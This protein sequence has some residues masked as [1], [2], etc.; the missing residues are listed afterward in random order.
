MPKIPTRQTALF[1]DKDIQK[2]CRPAL[3]MKFNAADRTTKKT[4]V[5]QACNIK[6]SFCECNS[7]GLMH[8]MKADPSHGKKGTV[9]LLGFTWLM[10]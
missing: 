5:W 7:S 4:H 8:I 9:L 1:G 6:F 2:F 3:F 10:L